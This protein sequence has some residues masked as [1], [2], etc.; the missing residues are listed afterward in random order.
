MSEQV[1]EQVSE[2]SVVYVCGCRS[3]ELVCV[4]VGV[5]ER[6]IVCV[7]VNMFVVCVCVYVRICVYVVVWSCCCWL[8]LLWRHAACICMTVSL[9]RA[10]CAA[11][12]ACPSV[13]LH[14]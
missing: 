11:A 8:C 4:S 7:C 14:K 12:H 6:D 10:K 2:C 1:S 13:L 3:G 9:L 5:C